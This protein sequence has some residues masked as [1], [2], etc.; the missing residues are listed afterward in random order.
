[1]AEDSSYGTLLGFTP[2]SDSHLVAQGVACVA[3][4]APTVVGAVEELDDTPLRTQEILR[5][6]VVVFDLE[7]HEEIQPQVLLV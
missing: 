1:M 6:D 3:G 5:V 7:E 4:D 2:S